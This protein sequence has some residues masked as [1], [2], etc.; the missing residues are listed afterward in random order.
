MEL[1]LL[2]MAK[3]QTTNFNFSMP[4][5]VASEFRAI[6]DIHGPRNKI[7]HAVA[8][9]AVLKLLEMPEGERIS[10]IADILGTKAM[11]DRLHELI[12]QAK[13][14]A[15]AGK[16]KGAATKAGRT[17]RQTTHARAPQAQEHRPAQ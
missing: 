16:P 1:Q 10:L 17:V 3:G 11:P 8:T 9:A 12:K 13:A 2:T 15:A 5:V 7:R 6:G 4:E 14:K